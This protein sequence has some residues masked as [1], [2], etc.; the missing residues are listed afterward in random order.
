M[1]LNPS[2]M[3]AGKEAQ[4]LA[5]GARLNRRQPHWRTA[6][7]A[8]WALVLCVEHVRVPSAR[9]HELSAEP[10]GRVRFVGIGCND[11]NLDVVAFRAFKQSVFETDRSR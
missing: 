5:R 9:R 7:G 10:T 11:A 2:A 8:L 1:P 6:S 3:R 4:V